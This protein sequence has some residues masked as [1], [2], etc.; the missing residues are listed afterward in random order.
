MDDIPFVWVTTTDT[1]IN[2]RPA[3]VFKL[4]EDGALIDIFIQY[5]DEE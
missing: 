3:T 1:V 5:K 4:Y 2:G